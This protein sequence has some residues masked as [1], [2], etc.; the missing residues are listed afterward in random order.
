MYIVVYIYIVPLNTHNPVI[1]GTR[2][3]MMTVDKTNNGNDDDAAATTTTTMMMMMTP[4]NPI[5]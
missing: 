1:I 4:I 2:I 3:T 5:F